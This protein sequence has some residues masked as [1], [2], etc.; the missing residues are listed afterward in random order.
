MNKRLR[1]HV[2]TTLGLLLTTALA[3]SSAHAQACDVPMLSQR[4]SVP[5]NV[6]IVMDNSGSMNE[7]M[8]HPDFDQN[9][10]WSGNFNSTKVYYIG[11]NGYRTPRNFSSYWPSSP[12]AYLVEG[13]HGEDGRYIGNYLNWVYFHATSEQRD[14]IPRETRQMVANSAVKSV[15]ASAT[16][17]RYG[18]TRFNYDNGGTV[19]ANCGTST[20]T[21]ES[22]VDGMSADSWTPTAE[23]LVSVLNYFKNTSGPIEYECQ[24]NFVIVVTD[25]LPTKDL[26]VP[27]W[28]G[29]ADGDGADPGDC[30][31]IG[32]PQLASSN[33]C[34]HWMDDVAYYMAHKDLRPDLDGEQTLVTYTIGFGLDAPLLESTAR[35]GDGLYR[36]AWDLD[37]LVQELGTVVGDIVSRIS[38]GAAVAVVSTE[39][40][41]DDRIYRGKFMP[42]Q[43]RG[44]LE[45]FRLPYSS[46]QSPI[47]EAGSILANR[48]PDSRVI[49]T[50]VNNT[51]VEFNVGNRDLFT[52]YIAPNGPGSGMASDLFGVDGDDD[53]DAGDQ[54]LGPDVDKDYVSDVIRYVRGDDVAGFRDRGGWVLGDLVYSTPVVVGPPGY[55]FATAA[56]QSFLATNQNREPV[57]YV[58][59]NDGMLHAFRASDGH[60]LWAYM[61]R[62]VLTKIEALADP[63][64]CHLS[65]V[66]LSPSAYDVKIGGQWK[67]VLLGGQR[68]GGDSYFALDVTDPYAP[69]VLWE[70]TV[71]ALSSSYTEP[72]LIPTNRGDLLWTGSGPNTSGASYASAVS[73]ADG[74]TEW[75][76]SLSMSMAHGGSNAA[77]APT[78]YDT[79][80]DGY[81]DL[82]F[83]GDLNGVL[84]R[85][86]L[87]DPEHW[88]IYPLFIGDQPIS[89]RPTVTTNEDG[90]LLV[91]FGTGKFVE[92]SDFTDT[93]SQ[94]FYCIKDPGQWTTFDRGDLVDQN[95][96]GQDTEGENGWYFDLENGSGERVTEPSVVLEGVVYFTSFAPSDEPCDAGGASWLYRIDYTTGDPIDTDEDG[97]LDDEDRSE[98]LGEGVASRPVV[99]LAGEQLI[100]QTSDARLNV[101]D[102]SIAPQPVLVRDWR[103]RFEGMPATADSTETNP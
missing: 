61:P 20:A 48:D 17:L 78:W 58:G 28:I 25:G 22:M 54:I 64:Y 92:G 51:M 19:V 95:G 49:F 100:V 97:D 1:E 40:G 41:T 16:G 71:P 6:M 91:F 68:T 33:D 79:D 103:E 38:S 26:A 66:D 3:T 65:Y 60:E 30:A 72:E 10:V 102:L 32:A 12:S 8:F 43:W 80:Y 63:N 56:Y 87:R 75:V 11:S 101:A 27:S 96:T 86:D 57:V 23:T 73:V 69:S 34:S 85:Y 37:T 13:L 31:S 93:S 55:F 50:N 70:T 18:L 24:K 82:A 59:A 99:N 83:Q 76:I 44:Y 98:S 52:N 81:A 4:V 77:T 74:H 62:E 36:V 29:D 9:V 45:S 5:P 84:W 53:F 35:N 2:M 90:D 42:G 21:L 47:W 15:M 14:S 67:T 89:G 39:T 88:S 46:G 94:S 7:A